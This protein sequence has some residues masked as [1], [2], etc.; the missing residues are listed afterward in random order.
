MLISPGGE[1]TCGFENSLVGEVVS[2]KCRIVIANP[3]EI[4]IRGVRTLNT[5]F[6]RVPVGGGKMG[7]GRSLGCRGILCRLFGGRGPSI[8][9]KCASGPMVCNSVT[10]GGTNI[11]RGITVVAK[12]NCTFATRAGGTGTVETIVSILCG[13]T[14]GYTSAIVFRGPSSERRFIS[15]KLIGSR[16][17]QIMGNSNIGAGH[18][19]ITSCPSGV[20]FFVLSHIVCSGKVHRCLETY[21]LIGRGRPRIEFVLLKT[22]R[23][24]RS[25]LSGRSLT[26]CIRGKVVRRFNRASEMR[27]C[28]GRYSM[29]ILPSCHRNAPEAI[30]R[31][32]DVN[33]TVV[34]ASTPKYHRA[35]VSKGAKFLIPMG[36]TRTITRGVARFVRGPRLVGA[37]N[38]TSTG[39]TH[40]GFDIS[41]IGSSVYY[42]LGVREAGGC[43]IM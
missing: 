35:I 3:G 34:A 25:S 9:L 1:A 7:P 2:Y 24:V 20:A 10:T 33:E 22:Y 30:L 29:C 42:R 19:S 38:T 31:T 15:S 17:Y 5:H 13:G 36:G 32:V 39:C 37:L 16:G 11:P 28:C 8:I 12:L 14:L 27:S 18:F 4:N 41:A 23:G 40:R 21:R 43:T 6:I 26:P